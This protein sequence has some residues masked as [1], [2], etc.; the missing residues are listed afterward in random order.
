MRTRMSLLLT[1]LL[2]ML[3]L[4]APHHLTSRARPAPR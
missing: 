3:P 4:I 2:T 1:T